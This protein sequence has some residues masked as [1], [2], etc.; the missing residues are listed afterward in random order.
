M[1]IYN[2]EEIIVSSCFMAVEIELE[3][4]ALGQCKTSSAS[5]A[6]DTLHP[7]LNRIAVFSQQTSPQHARKRWSSS[8]N[9]MA[10]RRKVYGA[11]WR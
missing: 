3:F 2:K 4:G 11:P 8:S 9:T 7:L 1:N 5:L 6:Q 10:V